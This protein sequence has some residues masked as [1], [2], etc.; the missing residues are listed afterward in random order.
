M[1]CNIAMFASELPPKR[2]ESSTNL[3]FTHEK[4]ARIVSCIPRSIVAARDIARYIAGNE[5]YIAG[6][7]TRYGVDTSHNFRRYRYDISQIYEGTLH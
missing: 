1:G 4:I 3:V 2:L 6:Y 5:G 7:E